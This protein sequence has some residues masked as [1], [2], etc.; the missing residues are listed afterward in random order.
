LTL[1]TTMSELMSL[2][3]QDKVAMEMKRLD[4]RINRQLKQDNHRSEQGP[5]L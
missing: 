1:P 2:C 4:K 5:M 3:C